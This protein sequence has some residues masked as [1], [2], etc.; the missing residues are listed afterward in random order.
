MKSLSNFELYDAVLLSESLHC[1][2]ELH[3]LFIY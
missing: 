2:S 3:D 1:A